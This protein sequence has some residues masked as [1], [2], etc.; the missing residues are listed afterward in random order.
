MRIVALVNPLAGSVPSD[1]V[2]QLKSALAALGHVDVEA[3]TLDVDNP[4]GQMEALN[5]SEP[6]LFIAWGGDGTLRTA[7]SA[8][9]DKPGDLLLLPGGTM[10]LL[11]KSIHGDLPWTEILDRALTDK[12]VAQL[13]AARAN[14][15]TFYCAML[16]GA[17]A[18]MAEARESLRR[19]KLAS[20][21]AQATE[22]LGALETIQRAGDASPMASS[23]W[24]LQ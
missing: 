10:N 7:L 21:V 8:T 6:D 9:Q 19:G 1:G 3:F 13:T 23:N 2:D 22:A 12:H 20:M 11:T 16:A 18:R 24:L 15:E 4:T 14:G 17:P 5:A